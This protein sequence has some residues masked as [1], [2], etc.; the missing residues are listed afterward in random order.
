MRDLVYGD[1]L[2]LAAQNERSCAGTL[3]GCGR[4]PCWAS[5]VMQSPE[6]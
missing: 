2:K 6:W 3:K 1:N 4:V 5:S